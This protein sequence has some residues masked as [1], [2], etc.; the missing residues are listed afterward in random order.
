MTISHPEYHQ[1]RPDIRVCATSA[2]EWTVQIRHGEDRGTKTYDPWESVSRRMSRDAAIA[3]MYKRY[4]L[5]QT[6]E[7]GQ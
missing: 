7:A 4:P 1:Q 5:R 2:G 3:S 6:Q